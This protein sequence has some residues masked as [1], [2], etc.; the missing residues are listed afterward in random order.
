M[1]DSRQSDGDC[2][3]AL[4]SCFKR[5]E[6]P[7][8]DV[9]GS[10][11]TGLDVL[12]ASKPADVGKPE[13]TDP[14]VGRHDSVLSVSRAT[15]STSNAYGPSLLSASNVPGPSAVNGST[16]TIDLW[17]EACKKVDVKTQ[18]W[19]ASLPPPDNAQNPASGLAEFVRASEQKHKQESLKI[20]SGDREILWRDYAN[21]VIP[22]V[23]AIGNIAINFAP[24]PSNVVWSA[25]KVLL[26]VCIAAKHEH[27][28]ANTMI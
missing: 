27:T 16:P 5:R 19:I 8:H 6:K 18:A 12:P 4:C 7:R 25:I 1:T 15:S 11:A 28:L 10:S 9:S 13:P 26:A 14:K 21:K 2:L 3:S 23:T 17:Q 24:A 22:V 20:K